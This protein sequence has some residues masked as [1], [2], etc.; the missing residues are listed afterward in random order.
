[1]DVD[2]EKIMAL[3]FT[4]KAAN[5]M[6][7]RIAITLK[8]LATRG[9]RDVIA[10]VTGIDVARLLEKRD[11]VLERFLNAENK[12]LTIDKLFSKI[13][14]KF[15]L[16]A[17][18]MP[19]F[20]TFESQH[21]IKLMIRFLNEVNAQG[22]DAELIALSLLSAKR[23]SDIFKLLQGLYAKLPELSGL[24]FH[25]KAP[26]HTEETI[27]QKVAQLVA[28]FDI[29]T[30]SQRSQ[31]T[32]HVK[33]VEDLLAKTWVQKESMQYWDFKKQY[34][35]EMDEHLRAIQAGLLAYMQEKENRFFRSL[36]SLLEIYKKSRRDLAQ[37]EGELSFD[38]IT[39]FVYYLLK[40]R[41]DSEF[42]YFRLDSKI[43]H[44]LL[45]EFQDTSVIQFDILRPIID[46]IMSGQGVNESGSFFFVGDVKQSIYRFRGGVSALF[47]EVASHPSITL[48]PLVTN[49]RSDRAVVEFVNQTFVTKIRGYTPQNVKEGAKEGYVEVINDEAILER[50]VVQTQLLIDAGATLDDIA[51]L[52]ATNADGSAIEA[53][54]KAESI[55]V[56]TETTAKLIHQRSVMAIIEYLK[57]CYF[58]E[59]LYAENFFALIGR[60]AQKLDRVDLKH[61]NL[62]LHVKKIIDKYELFSGDMNLL[63]FLEV[64][65]HYSDIEQF[66]FE[67][68]RIDK[69]AAKADLHG[70]RV[71][72]VHKSKGLEFKHVIVLDRLGKK[73]PNTDPII[74]EYDGTQL[75][76]IYLRQKNRAS[77]DADYQR[78]MDKEESAGIEDELNALYV[79]FTRAESSLFIIQKEKNSKFALLDL[80]EQCQGT[81]EIEAKKSTPKPQAKPLEYEAIHYG[82]QNDLI[83]SEEE[84]ESDHHAI[85]F[86][87]ALH[88]TLEMMQDF[89]TVSLTHAMNSTLNRYGALLGSDALQIIEKRI[90]HLIADA[91]FSRLKEG[92]IYK[93]QPLTY[94]GEL[95]YLD[96]LIKHE[97][98]WVIIDY[99]SSQAHS[100]SHHHQVNFYKK[101]LSEITGEKVEG[102][103]CYLL[104]DGIKL[105]EV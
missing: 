42:L 80:Q 24:E 22:K 67:Y 10:E 48:K 38:D 19:T 51:I 20:S 83:E 96:L 99:K 82:R 63:R 12:I 40:E 101:A 1:M 95:R 50:C 70:V 7:E 31:K 60:D 89:D 41:I 9:E 97:D 2:P 8:N 84:I 43:E 15:S 34:V 32:L 69:S 5:E 30:L 6:Q 13:L 35:S 85:T 105:L 25:E 37:N 16:H 23:L 55:E 17:G 56:V 45:D 3:T 87:L 33:D 57:Y 68:E 27:M 61:F 64:L 14:R 58:D 18:L 92:E 100:E 26:V 39:S 21:E 49:Y 46:E 79:A 47:G 103:L 81:L 74:Y 91:E 53:L 78:A 36:F 86:G 72:T 104:E 76:H 44:L 11:A 93:E 66:I 102:Y 54:L 90:K 62:S 94:E 28:L 73:Q 65:S 75:Q 98:R 88:Y 77:F 52:C 59:R 29:E 4:N 71:L